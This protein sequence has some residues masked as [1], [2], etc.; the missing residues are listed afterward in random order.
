MLGDFSQQAIYNDSLT[1]NQMVELL[2]EQTSFIR[3]KLTINCRNTK[4]IC[5]EITMITGFEPPTE[6]WSKVNGLP[7]SY[8][9]YSNEEEEHEQIVNLLSSL[10]DNHISPEKIT[11]LSPVKREQ[12]II[13]TVSEYNICNYKVNNKDKVSFCTIQ[14]YKGLENTVIILT[15]IDSISD[16][17]L[18]YVALSRARSGLYVIESDN[19]RTE[20]LK[21][22]LGRLKNGQ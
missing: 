21:L 7:V 9:M 14:G 16:K 1:G 4:M 6:V 15:D 8:L 10:F 20:Y 19:A 3:F 18:M 5:D 17:R 2:E 11:I 22:Q 13:D 12:S